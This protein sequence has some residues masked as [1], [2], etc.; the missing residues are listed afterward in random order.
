MCTCV[1]KFCKRTNAAPNPW[2][3][4]DL[5]ES[6]DKPTLQ[7]RRERGKECCSCSSLIRNPPKEAYAH[8]NLEQKLKDDPEF[9]KEYMDDLESLEERKREEALARHVKGS[10]KRIEAEHKSGFKLKMIMGY[11]WPVDV[12]K[13]ERKEVPKK[14]TTINFNGKTLRGTILD[15]SHGTPIGVVEME[16]YDSKG[17]AKVS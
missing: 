4:P 12:L 15:A 11:F 10:K 7:F 9:K 8:P 3:P 5:R 16:S 1:C 2:L 6:S 17:T 13:R 14:L